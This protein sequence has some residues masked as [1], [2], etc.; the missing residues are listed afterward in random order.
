MYRQ[1]D[2]D[3]LVVGFGQYLFGMDPKTGKKVWERDVIGPK[4]RGKPLRVVVESGRVFVCSMG[5]LACLSHATGEVHW[6]VELGAIGDTLLVREDAIFVGGDGAAAAYSHQGERLWHE[7]FA[8]YG[9]APVA[10]AF[11]G[12]QA[13]GDGT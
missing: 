2:T 12:R 6:K 7:G 10:L 5:T 11:P 3:W 8:G 1:A 9:Y 4:G 13:Q